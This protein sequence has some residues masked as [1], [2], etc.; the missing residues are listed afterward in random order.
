[1]PR[2]GLP[3]RQFDALAAGGGGAAT[4]AH[5]WDAER[6][7]RLLLLSL[8]AT[9]VDERAGAAGPLD[10]IGRA[11]E[12]LSSAEQRSRAVTDDLLLLPQT[13]QWLR[14]ALVRLQAADGDPDDVLAP[15]WVDVGQLHLTAAAAAVRT[16]LAFSLLV[17][18]R[19]GGVWLPSVGYA[20]LPGRKRPW[21]AVEAQ[22]DGRLLIVGHGRDSV[23]VVNPLNG[24]AARWRPERALAVDSPSGP[25]RIA[26][27]DTGPYRLQQD[28]APPALT[29]APEASVQRWAELVQHAMQVLARADPQGGQDVAA[30]LRSLEPLPPAQPFRWRSATMADS[31]G[32]LAA[33]EPVGTVEA[34]PAEVAQF[35]AVLTHEV[36]HS[37]LSALLHMYTLHQPDAEA[38]FYAPWRDDPRPLRGMLHGVY[39][40]TAVARFWRGYVLGGSAPKEHAALAAFEYALR[41]RQLQRALV[42]M[43]YDDG[44]TS[45]G[46]RVVEQLAETVESWG[47]EAV[48]NSASHEAER[49]VADH[50]VSWRLHHLVPD[51]G[52]VTG[53]ARTWLSRAT[54]GDAEEDM[55]RIYPPPQLLPDKGA[56]GLDARAVLMRMLL[57]DTTAHEVRALRDLGDAVQGARYAD[58]LLLE[59]D[60][61]AAEALYTTEIASSSPAGA[62][63]F[64][65]GAWAG[66]RLVLEAEGARCTA[67]EALTHAPELVRGVYE[68]VRGAGAGPTDPVAVADW[69]GHQVIVRP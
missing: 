49:A 42:Q 3:P 27:S 39:A 61:P 1:M 5:L 47:D 28:V 45:L 65:A 37:K 41:R 9:L 30:C 46:R 57:S 18:A 26:L 17:P 31:M 59:G 44:L 22:Y 24:P 25:K 51:Q 66:L 56:R 52:L 68:A 36:Q 29:E 33:S 35:A 21:E 23:R 38:R 55:R 11:W 69:I 63:D 19:S 20:R 50:A 67:V 64:T 16:G 53:L 54:P 6:S 14:Q 34:Q 8:L 7:R 10:G 62:G 32:G 2:H 60:L 40:F 12:V 43:V 13:G 58:L 4:I 48:G 15:L